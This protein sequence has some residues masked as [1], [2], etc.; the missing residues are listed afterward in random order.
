MIDTDKIKSWINTERGIEIRASLVPDVPFRVSMDED[1]MDTR[2]LWIFWLSI[3]AT[4]RWYS[5]GVADSLSGQ[6]EDLLAEVVVED[7]KKVSIVLGNSWELIEEEGLIRASER[8]RRLRGAMSPSVEA[9]FQS[10]DYEDLYKR[11]EKI[12]FERFT[13]WWSTK[14]GG[15]LSL[16]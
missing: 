15:V 11:R 16:N 4:D 9:E 13:K 14:H 6:P 1:I 2:D 10:L 7:L 8:Q 3:G 5:F 12:D